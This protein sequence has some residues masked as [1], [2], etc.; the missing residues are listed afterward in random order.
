MMKLDIEE[1]EREVLFDLINSGAIEQL[2]HIFIDWH[3]TVESEDYY[4]VSFA[5]SNGGD[6]IAQFLKK[7][8]KKFYEMKAEKFRYKR[9]TIIDETDD[10]SYINFMEDFPI[11]P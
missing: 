4:D 1:K 8:L 2:D 7:S 10:E 6:I 3:G 5:M 11:C 9:R